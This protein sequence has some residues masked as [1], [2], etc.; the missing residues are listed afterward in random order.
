[1]YKMKKNEVESMY[2]ITPELINEAVSEGWD[3]LEARNG[4]FIVTDNVLRLKN[5]EEIYLVEDITHI[6]KID[7][8]GVF[9]SDDEA[10]REAEK[11]CKLA[12][13]RDMLEI[14]PIYLENPANR[15]I[16]TKAL[17]QYRKE[18]G[19]EKSRKN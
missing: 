9:E 16:I 19:N 11:D 17:K 10:A 18:N 6:E 1:M 13:M 12:I 4:W 15:R 8:M 7:V 5:G 14:C 2:K 3:A